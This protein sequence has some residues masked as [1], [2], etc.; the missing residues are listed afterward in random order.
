MSLL[1]AIA[2]VLAPES[3][4]ALACVCPLWTV[5][6]CQLY[7]PMLANGGLGLLL[8]PCCHRRVQAPALTSPLPPLAPLLPQV[9]HLRPAGA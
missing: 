7:V 9:P 4:L 2:S 1:P 8:C 5:L 6:Q 3:A